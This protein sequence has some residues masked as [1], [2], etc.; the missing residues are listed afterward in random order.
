MIVVIVTAV[1]I[2]LAQRLAGD[3]AGLGRGRD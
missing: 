3:A 1:P 2:F